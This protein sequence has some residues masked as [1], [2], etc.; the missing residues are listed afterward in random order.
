MTRPLDP[1]RTVVLAN[2]TVRAS[3]DVGR[4]AHLFELVMLESGYNLLYED[5]RGVEHHIVGGWYELFPKAGPAATVGGR[6]ISAHGDVRNAPWTVVDRD[7]TWAEFTV[8]SAELPLR[9]TRRMQLDGSQLTVTEVVSNLSDHAV[10]Y[11]WGHHIT[12]G[13]RFVTGARIDVASDDIVGIERFTKPAASVQP[14]SH[15]AS[16]DRLPGRSGDPV[17]LSLF[18]SAPAAEMLFARTVR[19][20]RA[21]VEGSGVRL[22]LD[23]DVD[24]FPALW[25]WIENCGTT[26]NPFDGHT[27]GLALEPQSAYLP[28][29]GP[30]IEAGLAPSLP[31]GGTATAWL[32]ATLTPT[33]R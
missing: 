4:G 15:P 5:P 23:W 10:S 11:L 19:S 14:D 26:E 33:G 2:E 6:D 31:A 30:A 21:T 27:V 7:T 18:P 32:K 8:D 28:S 29:L 25:I 20:P 22:H 16:L 12:L 24:A 9:L 17:D 3:I 13:E 1:A